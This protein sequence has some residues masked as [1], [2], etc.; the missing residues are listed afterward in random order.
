MNYDYELKIM[1]QCGIGIPD[2]ATAKEIG[3]IDYVQD[4]ITGQ[5]CLLK[6]DILFEWP[7][8]LGDIRLLAMGSGSLLF[9]MLS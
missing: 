5:N 2:P 7:L 8:I 9:L 1:D 4:K 3:F 6:W